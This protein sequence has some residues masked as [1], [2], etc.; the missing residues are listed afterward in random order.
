MTRLH[1]ESSVLLFPLSEKSEL[2][3]RAESIFLARQLHCTAQEAVRKKPSDAE[4]Q[5]Q[6]IPLKLSPNN[7]ESPWFR[8]FED[9]PD[10]DSFTWSSNILD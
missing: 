9:D 4:P 8:F 3:N 5:K 1:V 7:F 10:C 6:D 2:L